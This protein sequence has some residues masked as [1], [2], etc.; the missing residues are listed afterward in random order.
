LSSKGQPL[1][2][3][4]VFTLGLIE[5]LINLIELHLIRVNEA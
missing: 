1:F 3:Q 5:I 4:S 2:P